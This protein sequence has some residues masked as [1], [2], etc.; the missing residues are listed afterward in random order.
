MAKE[1]RVDYMGLSMTLSPSEYR[2][3]HCI[4]YHSPRPTSTA[5]LTSLLANEGAK[6]ESALGVLIH[7]INQKAAE[8]D[9]RPLIVNEYGKGYRLRN[10]IGA[11][12]SRTTV[13][14]KRLGFL[15]FLCRRRGK[16]S[17]SS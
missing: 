15:G 9:P 16:A 12:T 10:G 7:R 13:A 5:L 8:V 6:N 2:V 11:E 17:T 14:R 1:N 3:L 4:F